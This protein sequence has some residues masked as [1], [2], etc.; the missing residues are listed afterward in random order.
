MRFGNL[1]VALPISIAL[2]ACGE[3]VSQ[4]TPT[5]PDLTGEWRLVS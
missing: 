3:R 2:V 4:G 5:G 1:C